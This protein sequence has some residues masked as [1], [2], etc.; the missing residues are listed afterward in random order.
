M[1]RVT[2]GGQGPRLS[3]AAFPQLGGITGLH[4]EPEQIAG[5]WGSWRARLERCQLP[6]HMNHALRFSN[7]KHPRKITPL[8]TTEVLKWLQDVDMALLPCLLV[9]CPPWAMPGASSD[10]P[11]H[12]SLMVQVLLHPSEE[13][14]LAV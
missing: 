1:S 10:A 9:K 4:L 12:F 11:W 3:G 6:D 5:S 2:L 7:S 14:A 8:D 13:E